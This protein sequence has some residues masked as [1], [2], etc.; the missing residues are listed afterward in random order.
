MIDEVEWKGIGYRVKIK[1]QGKNEVVSLL[2]AARTVLSI[3]QCPG[4]LLG[5]HTLH[6]GSCS[7]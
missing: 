5:L 2:P 3:N 7:L 6:C 4:E 1:V